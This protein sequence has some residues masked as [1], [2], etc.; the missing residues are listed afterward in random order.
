MEMDVKMKDIVIPNKNE[1]QFIE[2]AEKLGYKELC[3]LYGIKDFKDKS[4]EKYDTKLDISF[5]IICLPKECH[6]AKEQSKLVVVKADDEVRQTIERYKP[7]I[8]YDFENIPSIIHDFL[9]HRNSGMNHVLAKL[10]AKNKI[11]VGFSF[12]SVLNGNRTKLLGR[13]EQNIKLCKK[14]KC[15]IVIGSFTSDP[16]EMRNMKDIIGL[17]KGIGL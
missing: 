15:S 12:S 14:A 17:F 9:H 4:N 1:K 2:I 16:Y 7:N 5:G 13:I 11:S 6:K 10:C 3:F 8:I